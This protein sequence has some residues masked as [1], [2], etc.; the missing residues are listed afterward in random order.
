MVS[1]AELP[2]RPPFLPPRGKKNSSFRVSG[3]SSGPGAAFAQGAEIAHGNRVEDGAGRERILLAF[4][5]NQRPRCA[6]VVLKTKEAKAFD[7]FV[8]LR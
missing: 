8:S 7:D 5:P 3:W 6:S 2:A 1:T 4:V